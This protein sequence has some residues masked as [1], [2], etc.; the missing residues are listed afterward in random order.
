MA[1]ID[2]QQFTSPT[3][4]QDQAIPALIQGR[5][6]VGIAKT[7]TGKTAAFLL[8]LINK[9]ILNPNQGVL[10]LAPTREL[11]VQIRDEFYE[12]ARGLK[13]SICLCIGGANIQTQIRSLKQNPHFVVSTP[14]R[15]KDLINRHIFQTQYFTNVV[16][17]EVDRMLDIGFV[18]DIKFIINELPK[19]RQSA[20]FS[21]TINRE[22]EEIM[23]Q[24]LVDPV[25]VKIKSQDNINLI[26]QNVIKIAPHEAKVD[27]LH[28]LLQQSDYAKVM[29]FGRTK[30][31]IKKLERQLS[32]RGLKVCAIHG[33]KTQAARQRSLADFKRGYAQALLATD[34]AARGIDIDDVT[35]VINFD[36]PN[37]Y[38]DYIHR[39]G[40][41]GRAGKIGKALTFVG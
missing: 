14:G 22:T 40:R 23:R 10:I 34:V 32:E 19:K 11:A 25:Q 26:D 41:T 15:L 27:V 9:I 20:F 36:E 24:F 39:I 35:H 18:K 17:D 5:D 3:P 16:L 28:E 8:P 7:G 6:V 38:D 29:V 30:H 2:R 33:N 1:N 21:A 13:L 12:F 31:G 37:S 4:I